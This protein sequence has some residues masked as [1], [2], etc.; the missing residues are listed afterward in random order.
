MNYYRNTRKTAG[1]LSAVGD[2][3]NTPVSDEAR[4]DVGSGTLNF[5][6]DLE[7][8]GADGAL[9]CRQVE[10]RQ[11]WDGVGIFTLH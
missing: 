2:P 9:D 4:A 8:E 7:A 10:G 6:D 11:K 5:V 3:S 1:S